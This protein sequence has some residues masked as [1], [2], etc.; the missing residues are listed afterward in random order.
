M[1]RE[2]LQVDEI[3]YP[4]KKFLQH[5]ELNFHYHFQPG[6]PRDGLS[7]EIPLSGISQIKAEDLAWLVPGM[8]REKVTFLIK[9]L[10]KNLRGQCGHL[11]EAV[12]EFL[13]D[14]DNEED[15]AEAFTKFIRR[16]TNSKFRLNE[17]SLKNLP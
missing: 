7:V 3:Q 6:H 11:Q 13:T 17:K 2:A 10:P 14:A 8:I 5:L 4:E 16:K 12:T 1:Q 15:F 9:N